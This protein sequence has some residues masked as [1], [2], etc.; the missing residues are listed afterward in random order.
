MKKVVNRCSDED[1]KVDLKLFGALIN[2][3]RMKI[4]IEM[5]KNRFSTQA[6]ASHLSV[7]GRRISS[8]VNEITNAATVS[9][10]S[11]T[12]M[13]DNTRGLKVIQQKVLKDFALINPIQVREA[14]ADYSDSD[15]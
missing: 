9:K 5:Q 7:F 11:N 1:G 12:L 2:E 3:I 6:K 10:K 4:N 13:L 14:V 8:Q 15:E